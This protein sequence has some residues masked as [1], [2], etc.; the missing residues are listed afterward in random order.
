MKYRIVRK[1]TPL[2]YGDYR[3]IPQKR[4]RWFPIWLRMGYCF[5][6]EE[7]RNLIESVQNPLIWEMQ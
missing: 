5:S 6:M 4:Y 7:A 2:S 1:I 3:Y